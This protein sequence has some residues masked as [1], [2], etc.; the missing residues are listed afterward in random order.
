MG[1]AARKQMPSLTAY[2]GELVAKKA[3]ARKQ[4]PSLADLSD[5]ATA[6]S[7]FY[8]CHSADVVADSFCPASIRA[9]SRD[10]S[11]DVAAVEATFKGIKIILEKVMSN[12]KGI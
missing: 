8:K 7:N 9:E 1:A 12:V 3:A 10:S 11:A 5:I 6:R 2:T 4:M